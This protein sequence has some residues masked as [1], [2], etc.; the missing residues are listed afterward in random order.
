MN[1]EQFWSDVLAQRADEIRKY[2]HADAG[3]KWHCT[4]EHFSVDEY[5]LANCE[6][7]GDWD[8]VIE[9]MTTANDMIITETQVYSKVS[10]I[11]FHVV[12]FI[13]LRDDKIVAMD[14]YWADDSEPPKWRK[15]MGIGRN[16]R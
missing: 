15:D 12:S 2:F 8:G 9:R 4:N 16:I 1:I 7:P 6:Y 11:S 5:V 3:I 13:K 10:S 14:E